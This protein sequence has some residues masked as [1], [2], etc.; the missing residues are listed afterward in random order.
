[1]SHSTQD[2]VRILTPRSMGSFF[3]IWPGLA[4]T[5]GCSP[6]PGLQGE[7]L[8]VSLWQV[9]VAVGRSKVRLYVDCRKVAEKPMGEAG[10]P[11]VTGFVM[12][13]RLAKARGPRSSSATV[14][15]GFVLLHRAGGGAPETTTVSG[16]PCF[17]L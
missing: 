9:H 17:A 7:P 16:Q 3:P 12:L 15:M 1:M 2:G 10:S 8:V 4:G 5:D 11:P 6:P 14:S 13:G